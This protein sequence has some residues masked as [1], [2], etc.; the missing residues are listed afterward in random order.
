MTSEQD[1]EKTKLP[2]ER[3]RLR[4]IELA[5]EEVLAT[6]CKTAG[7]STGVGVTPCTLGSCAGEGS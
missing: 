3:P 1:K 5:A 2:Y 4:I 7:A 6:G